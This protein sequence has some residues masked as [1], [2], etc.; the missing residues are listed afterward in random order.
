[1]TRWLVDGNN[2]M[3]AKADGWWRDRPAARGR[4]TAR[5][6]ALGDRTGD[7][8]VV[9]FDGRPAPAES[10]APAGGAGSPPEVHFA[11]GGRDAAD[12]VIERMVAEDPDPAG[13][14]VVTSDAELARRVRHHGTAVVGAGAFWRLL[15]P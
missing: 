13:L 9:V 3:G 10:T 8:V 4:L 15:A 1:V 2:V 6:A 14:T 12:D 5:L 7:Q 11:P